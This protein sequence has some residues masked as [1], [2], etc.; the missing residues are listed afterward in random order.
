MELPATLLRMLEVSCASD[1]LKNWSI[2][3]E[4]DNSYCFK[5]RF[6]SNGSRHIEQD[7]SNSHMPSSNVKDVNRSFKKKSQSQLNRDKARS[8]D[9][10]DKRVTRSQ[11]AKV[12]SSIKNPSIEVNQP[13]VLLN[14]DSPIETDRHE[15]FRS[16]I[17]FSP[18]S[19]P[20]VDSTIRDMCDISI[21]NLAMDF[22]NYE[23]LPDMDHEFYPPGLCNYKCAFRDDDPPY[24]EN[25]TAYQCSKCPVCVCFPCYDSGGHKHHRK[26]LRLDDDC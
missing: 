21:N 10:H 12:A 9:W 7:I 20:Q 18:D 15:S 22:E 16:N 17:C 8:Q 11:A 13:T 25:T 26:F 14:R 1:V 5:I 6:V 4:K 24:S 2:Y 3:Q 19:I 23:E